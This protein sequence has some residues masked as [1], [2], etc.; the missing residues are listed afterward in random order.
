MGKTPIGKRSWGHFPY[1]YGRHAP[2]L[3]QIKRY[4][5]R[6]EIYMRDSCNRA[7]Q[8]DP[9]NTRASVPNEQPL[10]RNNQ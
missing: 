5:G 2:I 9:C 8:P 7:A 4:H 6:F 1:I 10:G 3:T